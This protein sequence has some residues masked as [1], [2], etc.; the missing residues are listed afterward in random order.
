MPVRP[1]GGGSAMAAGAL[2]SDGNGRFVGTSQLT[3]KQRKFVTYYVQNGG[4]ATAAARAAGYSTPATSAQGLTR[5]AAVMRAVRA[6]RERWIQGKI[7][8][9]AASAIH[10]LI[11]DADTPASV[12]FQVSRWALEAAGHGGKDSAGEGV[13][14][15]KPLNELT[16]DELQAF[17]NG[18]QAALQQRE[19]QARRTI[20]VTPGEQAA[21]TPDEPHSA[22]IRAEEDEGESILD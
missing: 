21:D 11:T 22:R 13:D 6:E 18:G 20:D 1:N 4:H 16:I 8:N 17:I 19:Q 7:A 15:D 3:D 2:T 9:A 5:S 10:D 12:R 14:N